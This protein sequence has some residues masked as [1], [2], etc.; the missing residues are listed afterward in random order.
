MNWIVRGAIKTFC[1]L[2]LISSCGYIFNRGLEVKC[3]L[4]F[5]ENSLSLTD[6]T[7]YIK[8]IEL[9]FLENNNDRYQVIYPDSIATSYHFADTRIKLKNLTKFEMIVQALEK[10]SDLPKVPLMYYY[11]S[12]SESKDS[13][14]VINPEFY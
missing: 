4:N 14:V 13:V 2:L 8:K 5:S 7:F 3:V 6:D 10:E 9:I 1:L 12:S 11:I